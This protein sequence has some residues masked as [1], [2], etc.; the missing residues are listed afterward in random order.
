MNY[1]IFCSDNMGDVEY[2]IIHAN[3]IDEAYKYMDKHYSG[4]DWEH[5]GT[6]YNIVKLEA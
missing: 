3:N 1:F 6:A 5:M 4:L 2:I